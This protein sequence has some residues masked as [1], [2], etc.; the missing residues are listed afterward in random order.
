MAEIARIQ[1]LER[2]AERP[3]RLTP[4]QFELQDSFR[5]ALVHYAPVYKAAQ[6]FLLQSLGDGRL[7]S[8]LL[9]PDDGELETIPPPR[10]WTKAGRT[11]INIGLWPSNRGP[12]PQK[13][14]VLV[15]DIDL[16]ALLAS[17]GSPRNVVPSPDHALAEAAQPTAIRQPPA[18]RP[19]YSPEAL[20]AWFVLR[21]RI[22]PKEAPAPIETQDLEAA[23]AYFDGEIA[24]DEF[25]DIR[26][27]KTPEDWRR[28]GPRGSR[29]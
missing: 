8:D 3:P 10:W 5:M 11:A 27:A 17:Q 26:R 6:M 18:P 14:Y 9:R 13:G 2:S 25:R 19:S 15:R 16:E 24:R 7:R 23:R 21:V 12:R 28:S 1:N 29:K 20:S 22:W 4:E